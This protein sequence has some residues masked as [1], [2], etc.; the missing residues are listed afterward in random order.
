[1]ISEVAINKGMSLFVSI[2]YGHALAK[3]MLLPFTYISDRSTLSQ[4]FYSAGLG[5]A[6]TTFACALSIIVL[7]LMALLFRKSSEFL[8][9]KKELG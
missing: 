4:T 3:L 1:M 6:S 8:T 2:L 9:D 5:C 7:A